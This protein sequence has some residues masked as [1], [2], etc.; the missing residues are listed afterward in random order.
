[1]TSCYLCYRPFP[2]LVARP[3]CPCGGL[4][5]VPPLRAFDPRTVPDGDRARGVFRYA[6]ALELPPTAHR[7]STLGEA[8]AP[9]QALALPDAPDDL[10]VLREDREP[11][12]SLHDAG[13]AL[14]VGALTRGSGRPLIVD[15]TTSHALSIARYASRAGLSVTAACPPGMGEGRR[16]VLRGRGA[17]I[18]EIPEAED[19]P[20]PLVGRMLERGAVD[21]RHG[22][23]ALAVLG[24]AAIAFSIVE[25]LEAAPGAVVCAAGHGALLA[26]L[27]AGFSAVSRAGVSGGAVP[28]LVGVQSSRCAP[29]ARAHARG[30]SRAEP[31][32]FTP[33]SGLAAEL[34]VREPRRDV[35]ALSAVR[36]NGGAIVAVDDLALE[37]AVRVL[38]R[39]GLKVEPWAAL[40]FAWIM[41]GAARDLLGDEPNGTVAILAADAIR[42]GVPLVDRFP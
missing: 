14:L 2:L 11:G 8:T 24:G 42:D 39:E 40:P 16:K 37:R 38:W 17:R 23:Q 36:Q 3:S 27:A 1:M 21:A 35:E 20:E 25:Q 7:P 29:L 13:A 18:T 26:G 19:G 34:L 22:T 6:A 10:L 31:P 28:R 41:S 12:G 4:P 32:K 15:A 9:L 33:P 30:E 5:A